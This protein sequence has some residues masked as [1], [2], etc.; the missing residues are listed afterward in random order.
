VSEYRHE[1][2]SRIRPG[3]FSVALTRAATLEDAGSSGGAAIARAFATD[4]NA[5]LCLFATSSH[6]AIREHS[7]A[8]AAAKATL[9][10]GENFDR[11]SDAMGCK[12]ST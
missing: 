11:C 7:C 2:L 12:P 8:T 4:G 9:G 10:R 5:Q 3:A 6:C 1:I